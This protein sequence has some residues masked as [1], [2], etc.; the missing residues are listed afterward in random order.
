[1][2]NN[3][4][5]GRPALKDE[6]KDV[7]FR[8]LEPYL[9]SGLSINKAC[10]KV[11]IPKSTIYD[12]CCDDSQFA[13][14]ID[15]AKSYYS[16]LVSSI[17]TKELERIAQNQS[18]GKLKGEELRFIQWVAVNSNHTREEYGRITDSI[19]R[20]EQLKKEEEEEWKKKIEQ[21]FKLFNI[22]PNNGNYELLTSE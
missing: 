9:K 15:T 21:L 2:Q 13:E 12:L 3:S 17:I 5:I 16:V 4:P 1:M 22:Q 6:E 18:K 10:L 8:K 11:Q 7:I 20:V 14:K 19:N